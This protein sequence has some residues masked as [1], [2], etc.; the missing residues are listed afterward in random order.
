MTIKVT[1]VKGEGLERWQETGQ[2]KKR[3][4]LGTFLSSKTEERGKGCIPQAGGLSRVS[5]RGRVESFYPEQTFT[6]QGL[7][8]Q[9]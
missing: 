7:M 6:R 1:V 8:L 9:P 2:R 4:S 3:F 5:R